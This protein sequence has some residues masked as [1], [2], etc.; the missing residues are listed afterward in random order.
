MQYISQYLDIS[1]NR[2]EDADWQETIRCTGRSLLVLSLLLLWTS[3]L[4]YGCTTLTWQNHSASLR[5]HCWFLA[6]RYWPSR[7]SYVCSVKEVFTPASVKARWVELNSW[8]TWWVLELWCLTL[9]TR[10]WMPCP[11]V[12]E[13]VNYWLFIIW[14][15]STVTECVDS[16]GDGSN[17]DE[18]QSMQHPHR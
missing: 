12:L 13:V 10:L 17:R 6:D 18:C 3:K 15:R 9:V 4:L 11:F 2:V 7:S 16:S 5:A 1:F 8:I 14:E